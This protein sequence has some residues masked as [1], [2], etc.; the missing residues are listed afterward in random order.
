MSININPIN[1]SP[2]TKTNSPLASTDTVMTTT[3]NENPAKVSAKD[4]SLEGLLAAYNAYALPANSFK[5]SSFKGNINKL[6]LNNIE[7]YNL[8]NNVRLI[9][10]TSPD[11]KQAEISFQLKPNKIISS[12]P[13]TTDILALMLDES[14]QN[15]SK[16]Q[17]D[18]LHN[19]QGTFI[20]TN[21]SGKT[22]TSM[23][24]LAPDKTNTA[25]DLIKEFIFNPELSEEKFLKAK[26]IIKDNYKH[27]SN[28]PDYQRE[29]EL[30][31]DDRRKNG[32]II[33]NVTLQDVQNLYSQIIN[34]S[35]GKVVVTT[36]KQTYDYLKNNLIQSFS[37]GIPVLHK[38]QDTNDPNYTSSIPLAKTKILIKA[39]DNDNSIKIKQSYKI[40][41]NG[42]INDVVSARLLSVILGESKDSRLNKD[43][44][45]KQNLANYVGTDCY[46]YTENKAICI[47]VTTNADA[48][49]NIKKSI[50]GINN[51]IN[52]LINKPVTNEELQNAKL[53]LKNYS[54]EALQNPLERNDFLSFNTPYGINYINEYIDTVDKITPD[55]LQKAAQMFLTQP[56]I[57][58]ISANKETLDKNKEYIFTLGEVED[59][60]I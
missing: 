21:I 24:K 59:L 8:P 34:N 18:E 32:Q 12:K 35:D 15:I 50:E 10:D 51:N 39:Q 60:K 23:V 25:P 36:P 4:I 26:Q 7:M 58:S 11:I 37:T 53:T 49:D 29:V 16:Q 47:S 6:D 13:F 48:K 42:N 40:I 45:E 5:I 44:K 9:V 17:K 2:Y 41:H 56:S 31:C 14:S 57:I 22:I 43:L 27:F 20:F 46:E 28:D 52:D 3:S 30:Y 33:D 54:S 1:I 19:K 38:Y 55:Q